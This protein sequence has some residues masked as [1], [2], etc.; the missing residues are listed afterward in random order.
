MRFISVY[1]SS[2]M[3]NKSLTFVSFVSAL[4]SPVAAWAQEAEAPNDS[5]PS[6]PVEE[7]R[8]GRKMDL[9]VPPPTPA[10]PQKAY[11]HEGFYFRA[12]VGPGILYPSITNQATNTSGGSTGFGVALDALVGGSPAPGLAFGGGAIAHVGSGG[13]F[14]GDSVGAMFHLNVGPFFDAFPNRKAGFHLGVLLGGSTMSLSSNVS[15]QRQLWGGGGAL[16]LGWDAWVAPE[17]SAGFMLQTGGSY[18]AATDVGAAL[19]HAQLLITLL[20]H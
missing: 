2:A 16:W 7:D 1:P 12:A 13:K 11:V 17:W 9:R 8:A 20:N 10:A 4:M 15:P 3:K 14:D 19:F 18:V 6:A 5:A